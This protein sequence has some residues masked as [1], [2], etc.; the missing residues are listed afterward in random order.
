MLQYIDLAIIILLILVVSY[1]I[2]FRSKLKELLAGKQYPELIEWMKKCYR[3][4]MINPAF[5]FYLADAA[6]FYGDEA[7][8]HDAAR[9]SLK[10][11]RTTRTLKYILRCLIA[12]F[13][14]RDGMVQEGLEKCHELS[15]SKPKA[16][17]RRNKKVAEALTLLVNGNAAFHSGDN[18]NARALLLQA[19]SGF[20]PGASK[21]LCSLYLSRV[22]EQTG[23][24]E[25]AKE[26]DAWAKA[27]A[28]GTLYAKS[29]KS[30]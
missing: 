30:S 12:L 20:S 5:S 24:A 1:R 10:M 3:F 17:G 29:F 15:K 14:F 9:Y 6:Y 2:Y 18:V 26:L 19:Y 16:F 8:F 27:Y 25:H 28:V 4:R 23:E 13:A 7:L 11:K 21:S 22:F